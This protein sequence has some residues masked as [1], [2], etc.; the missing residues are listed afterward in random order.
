LERPAG[1]HAESE[2][3]AALLRALERGPLS[4]RQV[5]EILQYPALHQ[6]ALARLVRQGIIAMSAITPTDAAHVLGLYTDWRIPAS[7]LAM[8]IWARAVGLSSADLAR[9][10]LERTSARI[11][12]EIAR[13][14]WD[15]DSNGDRKN[16][17]LPET[18]LDRLMT[19]GQGRRMRFRPMLQSPIVALGAPAGTYFPSV[20][21]LLNARVELPPLGHVANAIG[22]IVGSVVARSQASVLPASSDQGYTVQTAGGVSEFLEFEDAVN[23]ARSEAQRDAV[24][25]ATAAGAMDIRVDLCESVSTAPVGHGYSGEV[26]ISTT[27]RAQAIGR[28]RLARSTETV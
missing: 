8:E 13:K 17:A 20:A 23:Y 11:A 25:K 12:Q 16:S 6:A 22:A 18:L 19:A 27:I 14:A 5:D 4:R 3:V 2:A 10:I 28:P 9:R 7:A 15:E 24:Q 1:R 21:R 26:F